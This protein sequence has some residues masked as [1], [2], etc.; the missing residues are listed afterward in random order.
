MREV[1]ALLAALFCAV[2]HNIQRE[3]GIAANRVSMCRGDSC[4]KAQLPAQ[5]QH[6]R[7]FSSIVWRRIYHT[8][9][10]LI[11]CAYDYRAFRAVH[12]LP[13]LDHHL[14]AVSVL[15]G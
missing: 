3:S 13:A 14:Q 1:A 2:L 4:S 7:A 15:H 12:R 11:A 6:L 9:Q 8:L 10:V 5:E